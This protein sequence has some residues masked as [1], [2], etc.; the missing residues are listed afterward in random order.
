[1]VRWLDGK[2]TRMAVEKEGSEG[3]GERVVA[4]EYPTKIG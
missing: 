4:L 2:T 3:E 1:M